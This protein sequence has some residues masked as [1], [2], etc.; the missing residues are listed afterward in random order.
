MAISQLA[1]ASGV[2]VSR[3]TTAS[4]P[5]QPSC[6]RISASTREV[7]LSFGK[8]TLDIFLNMKLLV[9]GSPRKANLKRRL[10]ST[11]HDHDYTQLCKGH[12][13]PIAMSRPGLRHCLAANRDDDG[14]GHSE[15]EDQN[16]RFRS[17]AAD[18]DHIILC[19]LRFAEIVVAMVRN[20]FHNSGFAGP[21]AAHRT[22]KINV[23][24]G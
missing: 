11:P 7:N 15:I 8:I 1:S 3:T 9:V 19:L 20:P 24:A 22:G 16:R 18:H 14:Q 5:S 4:T 10:S 21:A 23:D 13:L 12:Q 6:L 17:R 2:L